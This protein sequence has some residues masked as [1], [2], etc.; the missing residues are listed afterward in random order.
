MLKAISTH[1]FLKHRLH[2]GH[3]DALTGSGAEAIEIFAARQHFDYTDRAQVTDIAEWF[4]A[5]PARPW[6]LHAPLYSDQENGRG[7][8]PSV[9]VI[10]V[11]KGRRI[12]AMD[13]IK[14]ALESAEQISFA[15]MILHLGERNATWSARELEHA[16]TA[17]EHLRAFARPLGVQILLENLENEVTQPQNLMEILSVGH[18]DDIGVCL[19]VGHAHLGG[20]IPPAIAILGDRIRSTHIHDNPGDRD[21]HL[22]PGEGTISWPETMQSLARLAQPPGTVLEI[23]YKVE[24]SGDRLAQ[25]F[26]HTFELLEMSANSPHR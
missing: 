24:E 4:H 22:W 5:N 6:A 10:H 25:K 21:A 14:R 15:H 7:G 2:G 26:R 13:E 17:V 12:E 3:L 19:D 9:N 18:F 1:I 11:E 23:S 20:G 16:M 8:A